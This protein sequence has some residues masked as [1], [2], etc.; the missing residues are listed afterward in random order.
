MDYS[1]PEMNFYLHALESPRTIRG[2][3]V[4]LIQREADYDMSHDRRTV[5]RWDLDKALKDS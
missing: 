1:L 5:E 4:C 2:T 3:H